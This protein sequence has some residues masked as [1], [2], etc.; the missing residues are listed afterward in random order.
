M[1]DDDKLRGQLRWPQDRFAHALS[2]LAAQSLVSLPDGPAPKKEAPPLPAENDQRPEYTRADM[3]R[4]LEGGEF[5]GLTR[6]VEDK[7]GKKLTTPDLSTLLGLYDFLGLPTDVIFLLVGFC[8]ER[9]AANYGP[10]RRPTLRQI[11]REGYLWARQGLFTQESAAAY[12]RRYQASRE[13]LPR[14]MKL[15]GLGD[16]KPSPSEERYLLAWID[17]GFDPGAVELAY[18]KTILKCKEL[19]WAYLDK[20]LQNWHRKGLHTAE[21]AA[22]GDRPAAPRPANARPPREEDAASIRENLARMEKYRKKLRQER[23]E[24]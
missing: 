7:L 24:N 10:G 4:A 2:V 8:C 22:Q 23:E 12:I 18:D 6:A 11:E 14:F 9:T 20:I 13:K 19:K 16:R 21:E 17:M 15:L 1:A 3:A 5:A